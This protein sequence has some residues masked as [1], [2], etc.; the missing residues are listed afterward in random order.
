MLLFLCAVPFVDVDC[1]FGVTP[2][3]FEFLVCVGADAFALSCILL[4][5]VEIILMHVSGCSQIVKVCR[6]GFILVVSLPSL[7]TKVLLLVIFFDMSVVNTWTYS[8]DKYVS[9]SISPYAVKFLS[10]V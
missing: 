3:I 6:H 5:G 10:M 8:E 7:M 1:F 2:L 4:V 9:G